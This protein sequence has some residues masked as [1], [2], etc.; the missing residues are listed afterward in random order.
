[1][2]HHSE[3][4][5]SVQ[6]VSRRR[7]AAPALAL[8]GLLVAP[9]AGAGEISFADAVAML[10]QRNEA[11]QAAR[12]EVRLRQED[13]GAARGL[14]W[15]KLE[16]GWRYTRIDE[17]IVID[18]DPIRQVI[19]SLHRNVPAAAVPPF[20]LTVQDDTF[21]KADVRASWTLFTGGKLAAAEDAARAELRA[22]EAGERATG[23]TLASELARRYFALRLAGRA[24]AVR[25]AAADAVGQH[26]Q[27]ARRLEEEG[28]I[29]RAERLHADMALAEAERQLARSERD[30]ELARIALAALISSDEPDLAASSPIAVLSTLPPVADFLALAETSN[31]GLARLRAMRE[32]AAVG[33]RAEKAR[34]LPD[35]FVFGMHELHPSDLTL[36]EPRW[37]VGVG[38][39]L[40]LFDGFARE[41]RIAAAR[42]RETRLGA[43]EARARRDI[44][45][46]VEKRYRETVTARELVATLGTTR[47]LAAENLRVRTRAFEEGMGTSLEVVDA[48]L[49]ASRVEL[50]RALAGYEFVVA[51]AELLEASGQ[52]DRLP[53][54]LARADVEVER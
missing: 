19:L 39:S 20:S 2:K 28:M 49:A 38:A 16:A 1:M 53:E 25:A 45:T 24:R 37:A 23:E 12:A 40:T 18:L 44:A 22:A 43:L 35:V 29:A 14:A 54:L 10:R 36:L 4:R 50:E 31:P 34:Y 8:G 30:E 47:E 51:L 7:R 26:A 9:L 46:L 32:L 11:L 3:N 27:H 42:E 15:P 52:S 6:P 21:W 13:V 48:Q 33:Q 41:H 5:T 17:P